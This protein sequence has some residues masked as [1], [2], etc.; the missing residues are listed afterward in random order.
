L[1]GY[2]GSARLI[3]LWRLRHNTVD[4]LGS[5][6][7]NRDLSMG[8]ADSKYKG[9]YPALDRLPFSC[10]VFPIF[11]EEAIMDR[12]PK[13]VHQLTAL[14]FDVLFKTEEDCIRYLVARRWPEGV[15]CPRCGSGRVYP[16]STMAWKWQCYTCTDESYRFSHLTGTIFENTNK[17]LK[18]WYR[19]VHLMLV[20]KKGMSALQICRYMGFG[21]Y[22]TAW[23]MCHKV[24]VA[25]IEDIGKLGGIVEVDETYVGG[26]D[27]NR[28]WDKKSGTRGRGD[29]GKSAI[30]G[31]VKR[32]GN[33][34]ARVV[35]NTNRLTLEKFVRETVSTKVSLLCTDA[36]PGYKRLKHRSRTS[37][38]TTP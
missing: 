5:I 6:R 33:V 21:S 19:V 24:R 3:R 23:L 8:Y 15:R 7:P 25:L 35:E 16:V 9:D 38:L 29:T 31:A 4:L 36:F 32:K 14:Q 13:P 34:V 20:S 2:V 10:Y 12:R 37:L 22:K 11:N 17:P 26:S 28:H 18:D 27:K 30:V 1:L